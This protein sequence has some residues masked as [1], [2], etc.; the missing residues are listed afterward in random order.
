MSGADSSCVAEM[1]TPSRCTP[2]RCAALRIRSWSMSNRPSWS[3]TSTAMSVRPVGDDERACP[4]RVRDAGEEARRVRAPAEQVALP[5]TVAVAVQVWV[6]RRQSGRSPGGPGRAPRT[7]TAARRRIARAAPPWS[8]SPR[9]RRARARAR[10]G[11]KSPTAAPTRKCAGCPGSAAAEA[12]GASANT[13]QSTSTETLAAPALII[14]TPILLPERLTG[15]REVL[16]CLPY[17][18]RLP[19]RH[20]L[21]SISLANAQ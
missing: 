5:T 14:P 13:V 15:L 17:P 20:R 9:D 21:G 11:V 7:R 10:G 8:R 16:L 2:A 12:D 6:A 18:V 1:K 4:D 3:T 19:L